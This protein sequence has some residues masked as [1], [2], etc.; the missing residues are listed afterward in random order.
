MQTHLGA[1]SVSAS[2]SVSG[3]EGC[4]SLPGE[5]GGHLHQ[6]NLCPTFR[7]IAE[8]RMLFPCLLLLNCL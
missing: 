1:V 7:H 2:V 3:D 8:G 4:S 5:R 6:G